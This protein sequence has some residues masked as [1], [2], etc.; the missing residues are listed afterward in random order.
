MHR[1]KLSDGDADKVRSPFSVTT[2]LQMM[3]LS[4]T[5]HVTTT[6]IKRLPLLNRKKE[7]LVS[8]ATTTFIKCL[9][10][11]EKEEGDVVVSLM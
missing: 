6:F 4:H 5:T 10:R 8:V 7:T 1:L 9:P 11:L 3:C 2:F